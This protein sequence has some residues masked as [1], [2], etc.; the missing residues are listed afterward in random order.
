MRKRSKPMNSK[1]RGSPRCT[2]AFDLKKI[3]VMNLSFI[4]FQLTKLHNN[5]LKFIFTQGSNQIT[6][7]WTFRKIMNSAQESR[8]TKRQ[9][10]KADS[11]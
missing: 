6:I 7:N 9:G 3:R 10:A 1:N 2:L 11:E 4:H 8:A 5:S